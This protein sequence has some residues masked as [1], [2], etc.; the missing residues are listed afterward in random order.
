MTRLARTVNRRHY[1]GR[2]EYWGQSA[3]VIT[4]VI[5]M[6]EATKVSQK[7]DVRELVSL[8]MLEFRKLQ[9]R[10]GSEP[11]HGGHHRRTVPTR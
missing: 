3:A 6:F 8:A 5:S 9:R 10:A 2:L 1:S 11:D 7:P 4:V